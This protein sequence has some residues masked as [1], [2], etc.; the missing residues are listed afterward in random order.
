MATDGVTKVYFLFGKSDSVTT[1]GIS[2]EKINALD[3]IY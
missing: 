1:D 2:S 3:C